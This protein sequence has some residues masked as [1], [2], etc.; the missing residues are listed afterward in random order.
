[1]TSFNAFGRTDKSYGNMRVPVWLGTVTA[2]PVG[3]VLAEAFVKTGALYP[4]GTPINLTGGVIKP[5]LAYKVKAVADGV[6]TVAP[7][8]NIMPEVGDKLY[9]AGASLDPTGA[10]AATAVAKNGN[11]IDITVAIAGLKKD[12]VLILGEAKPNA[13][14]Y[15]DIYFGDI[16]V[17]LE[18]A[19]ASGAA[20]M[21]HSEGILIDR[22]PAADIAAQM[23]VAVPGVLQVNG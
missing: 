18:G 22:T 19:G 21:F 6:A 8:S 20:V 5:V 4:A 14:L 11:D 10:V 9:K 1:M 17:S 7:V 13:Y 15:N 23:A 12:D 2:V 16:D 3:G